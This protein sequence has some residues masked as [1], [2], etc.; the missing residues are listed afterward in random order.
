MTK[1]FDCA[2]PLTANT[3]AAFASDP[4]GYKFACRYLVP[5]G[6]KALTKAEAELINQ[7]GLDYCI[8][9]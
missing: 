5:S 6:W 4:D 1:G 3:A 7:A 8:C 2:T 9:V